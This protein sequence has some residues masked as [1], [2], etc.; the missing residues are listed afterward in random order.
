MIA[1]LA[2]LLLPVCLNAVPPNPRAWYFLLLDAKGNA[3]PDEVERF[4]SRSVLNG[5]TRTHKTTGFGFVYGNGNIY[6]KIELGNFGV[7]WLPGDT[8]DVLICRQGDP[9]TGTRIILPIPDGYSAIWWGQPVTLGKEYPGE[10]VRLYP[11]HLSVSVDNKSGVKVFRDSLDTGFM[12]GQE[13]VAADLSFLEGFYSLDS[14]HQGWHWEPA[15]QHVSLE[16]FTLRSKE[17]EDGTTEHFYG[18]DIHFRLVGGE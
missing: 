16:D 14:P 8:L 5:V 17:L 9:A 10:P 15:R 3:L 7:E 1:S 4:Q 13:I 12:T 2:L 11:F 18:L 6:A